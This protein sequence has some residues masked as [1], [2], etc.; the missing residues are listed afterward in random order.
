MTFN[1]LGPPSVLN[2]Y[3]TPVQY[4][5]PTSAKGDY[6]VFETNIK[7]GLLDPKNIAVVFISIYFI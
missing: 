5:L 4:I 6:P 2:M 7:Y 3:A 1:I